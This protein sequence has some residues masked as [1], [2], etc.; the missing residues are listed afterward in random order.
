MTHLPALSDHL[1]RT[2]FKP[3]RRSDR[4]TQL[5]LLGLGQT[6]GVTN[7]PPDTALILASGASNLESTIS[8]CEQIFVDGTT[9]NPI[10]FINSVNNSTAYHINQALTI[11]GLTI[12]VS[13]DHCSLEA[14]LQLADSLL[15]AQ[16]AP[17]LL[18]TA[19]EV[20]NDPLLHRRR[21]GLAADHLLGEGSFWFLCGQDGNEPVAR[22]IYNGST[23]ETD[24][25]G[26]LLSDLDVTHYLLT[27][28]ASG[29][30]RQEQTWTGTRIECATPGLYP[31]QN[32]YYL[33]RWLETAEKGERLG[34][35]NNTFER[36]RASLTVIDSYGAG[37]RG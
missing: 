5:A 37:R 35:I 12:T 26:G 32:A 14:G 19:D 31:T 23:S 27:D 16:H 29:H 36:N 4:L 2:P 20:P 11:R 28:Q 22:V 21:T 18:G 8:N 25:I 34:L 15:Q 6:R 7:L 24:G 3:P 17:I 1:R 13:R 33:H 10:G 30:I 9:P